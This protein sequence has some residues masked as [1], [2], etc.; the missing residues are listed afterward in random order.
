MAGSGLRVSGVGQEPLTALLA[1]REEVVHEVEALVGL[2]P[3]DAWSPAW[4]GG[5]R[6][7]PVLRDLV[8]LV[9]ASVAALD[10]EAPR[11]GPRSDGELPRDVPGLLAEY[12]ALVDRVV[13]L[14]TS[15]VRHDPFLRRTSARA[16]SGPVVA[17]VVDLVA[18]SARALGELTG[19]L[20]P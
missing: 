4:D 8:V 7:Q 6:A 18:D 3:T 14:L 17:V 19:A 13:V 9:A 16:T 20:G 5:S 11:D 2:D 1:L 12:V 15:A 10:E